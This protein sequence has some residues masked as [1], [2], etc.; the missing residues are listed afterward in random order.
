MNPMVGAGHGNVVL[1]SSTKD[2]ISMM[3]LAST[4]ASMIRG[5]GVQIVPAAQT[6]LAR[7]A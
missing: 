7:F 3:G 1:A 4:V 5:T 2:R 6:A